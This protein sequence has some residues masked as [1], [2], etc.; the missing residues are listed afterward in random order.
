M[1]L[2]IDIRMPNWMS[3]AALHDRLA[4]LL[5]DVTI[6]QGPPVGP[7][8][9]VTML[10]ANRL[11]SGLAALLPN[12]ALVQKLGAGVETMVNAAELPDHV[13]IARLEPQVQADEITE[14]CLAEIFATLRNIRPYLRQQQAA[15]WHEHAPRRAAQTRVAVLGLGHIGQAVARGSWRNGFQVSGWSRS[16][17]S[18]DGI[19]CFAGANGLDQAV[20]A[21]DFVVAVL[22]STDET[23]GLVD[24]AFLAK[25]KTGAHLVNVGRGDLVVEADLIA[26]LQSG[27]L[28]GASLDVFTREP[29]QPDHPFWAMENVAITPHV[30]GWSL[31][32]GVLDVAENYRRLMAGEPLLREV[33]RALGY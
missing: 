25:M 10:A 1:S 33:D 21:A 12:L 22:P 20:G 14:Y 17:K 13:R 27:Q 15:N 8:P 11:P 7:L 30:S 6:H 9:D 26:A 29:L 28:S 5:P 31:G 16:L 24:A 4:P 32:D 18:L 2:L 3:D 19:A 23:R